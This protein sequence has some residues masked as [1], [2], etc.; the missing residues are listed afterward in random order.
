MKTTTTVFQTLIR[1]T[2]LLQ[3]ALGILI[4][5]GI[6]DALIP[7]HM[8]NGLVLVASLLALAILGAVAGVGWGTVALA[9]LFVVIVPILGLTQERI[10]PGPTHWLIQIVHLLLGLGAIGLGEALARRTKAR[11]RQRAGREQA[12]AASGAA[13]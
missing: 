13:R 1:L 9:I 7:L 5:V 6:A 4:W 11:L 12:R 2:G 8:L 3:I 10:L